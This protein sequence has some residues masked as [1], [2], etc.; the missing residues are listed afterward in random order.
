MDEITNPLIQNYLDQKKAFQDLKLTDTAEL[1]T[2]NHLGSE[3]KPIRT[4]EEDLKRLTERIKANE[5][6]RGVK[7]GST[8]VNTYEKDLGQ[9]KR[10][11]AEQ[12]G[13]DG[14]WNRLLGK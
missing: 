3:P 9:A 7:T 14:F 5:G 11:I 13:Q 4:H 12:K 1:D 2:S 8:P 6:E 10:N